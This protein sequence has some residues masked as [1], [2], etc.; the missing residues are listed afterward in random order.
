[1]LLFG[2][3][4]SPSSIGYKLCEHATVITTS[5]NPY[6]QVHISALFILCLPVFISWLL[7]LVLWTDRLQISSPVGG[8][9]YEALVNIKY[10]Y[11]RF[12]AGLSHCFCL[13]T[14]TKKPCRASEMPCQSP[15]SPLAPEASRLRCGVAKLGHHVS[16]IEN[17]INCLDL[18]RHVYM[19][20][21]VSRLGSFAAR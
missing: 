16:I 5:K 17:V 1:M 2:E 10:L 6:I 15:L 7:Y 21:P 18:P 9:V 3:K 12:V 14:Y 11:Y 19:Y 4:N 20:A 13:H 8:I